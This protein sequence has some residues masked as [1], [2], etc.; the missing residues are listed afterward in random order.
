MSFPVLVGPHDV[1]FARLDI[2]KKTLD[3]IKNTY[4]ILNQIKVDSMDD[5]DILR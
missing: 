4:I 2:P 5:T 3:I 1:F